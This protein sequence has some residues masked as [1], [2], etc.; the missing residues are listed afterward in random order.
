MKN[1]LVD[2]RKGKFLPADKDFGLTLSSEEVDFNGEKL[3]VS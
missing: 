1:S 2:G 3:T